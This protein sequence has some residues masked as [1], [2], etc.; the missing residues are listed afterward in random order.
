MIWHNENN[1]RK[2]LKVNLLTNVL[3]TNGEL[4][5]LRVLK[6]SNELSNHLNSTRKSKKH[7]GSKMKRKSRK[8]IAPEKILFKI[9][10]KP[11]K[12][13]TI[14]NVSNCQKRRCFWSKI[15]KLI[16]GPLPEFQFSSLFPRPGT[17]CRLYASISSNAAYSQLS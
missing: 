6:F 16:F 12:L 17:P 3:W 4:F 13:I 2:I 14:F 15:K 1:T 10:D 5:T 11:I 8:I 9:Q 7:L